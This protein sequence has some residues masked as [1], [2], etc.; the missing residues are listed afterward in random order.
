MSH[1]EELVVLNC[2]QMTF[3]MDHVVEF[4]SYSQSTKDKLSTSKHAT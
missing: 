2:F 3:Q 1:L 4:D